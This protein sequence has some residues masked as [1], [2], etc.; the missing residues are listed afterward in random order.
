MKRTALSLALAAAALLGAVKPLEVGQS[1]PDFHARD[2]NGADHSLSQYKGKAV[3][4]EWTNSECPFVE[5]HYQAGDMQKLAAA[6][7]AKEV[8]WLAVNSTYTNTPDD[9]K[10]W[11]K[12]E[13]FAYPTLQDPEGKL[14]HMFGARTTPHMFVIDAGGV[15]RYRGAIDDDEYGRAEKPKNYVD[16]AV[17]ALLANASPDP[18]ETQ[19]YGCSVKYKP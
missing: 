11:M 13:G 12:E 9:T 16:G 19:S 17:H 4:L 15:L 2:Q 18:A 14:G 5:R 10:T 3:V 6:L 7:G 8:V 1:V